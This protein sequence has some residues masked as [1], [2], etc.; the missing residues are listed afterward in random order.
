LKGEK[1]FYKPF[2]DSL[3]V[4]NETLFSL[5]DNTPIRL[6]SQKT[7]V[8]EIGRK[9]DDIYGKLKWDRDINVECLKRFRTFLE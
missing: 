7:L 3:P 4:K 1:S 9:D 8:S 6:G 5:P 2:F